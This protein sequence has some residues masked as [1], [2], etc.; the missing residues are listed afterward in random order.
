[1]CSIYFNPLYTSVACNIFH[2]VN[3][4]I[5]AQK[6]WGACL[7]P[8]NWLLLSPDQLTYLWNLLCYCLLS[9]PNGITSNSMTV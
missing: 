2:F 4:E 5:K 6:S 7:S 3:E 1:M 8:P 9:D